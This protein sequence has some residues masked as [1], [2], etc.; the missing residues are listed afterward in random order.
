MNPSL[1]EGAVEGGED[2]AR[3]EQY[4]EQEEQGGHDDLTWLGVETD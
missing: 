4:C 3:P 1:T 2:E